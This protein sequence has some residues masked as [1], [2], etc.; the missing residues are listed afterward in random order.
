MENSPLKRPTYSKILTQPTDDE[1]L[2]R[3]AEFELLTRSTE[4]LEKN[5]KEHE[6][7]VNKD[8]EPSSSDFQ[9]HFHRI[10]EQRKTHSRRRKT[11]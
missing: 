3:A 9:R 5:E 10:Q 11:L 8:P 6:Q 7:E 4:S 1:L 2:T